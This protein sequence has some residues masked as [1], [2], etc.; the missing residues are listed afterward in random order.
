MDSDCDGASDYDADGDGED[1]D[2]YGGSDCD[3]TDSGVNPSA[4]DTWYDGV[5]SDC[6]GASDYDADGDGYDS[7]AWSGKDCDDT[8]SS[9]NPAASETLDGVDEDCSG[10]VDDLYVSAAEA[11]VV[12]GYDSSMSVGEGGS[13]MVANDV[14]DD[15]DVE[16][17]AT[18]DNIDY[19]Y[20]W[21]VEGSDLAG[22]NADL[23][24][25]DRAFGEGYWD[26]YFPRH[27]AS[28]LGDVD[29]DGVTELLFGTEG[30]SGDTADYG[31]VYGFTG[32]TGLASTLDM[33]YGDGG[34]WGNSEDDDAGK[35]TISDV[36]GDGIGDVILGG[37]AEGKEKGEVAVF[38]GG[39]TL[40]G[41]LDFDDADAA[42][43]GTSNGDEL[44]DHLTSADLD[45]DGYGDF[46]ASAPGDDDGGTDAGA[47]YLF[48]GAASI[49]W[50]GGADTA[51]SVKLTSGT[52]G[53]YLGEDP[54]PV[55]GDVDGDGD[56]D[57]MIPDEDSGQAWLFLSAGSLSSTSV[58][59][60][61]HLF[62][63]T[64]GDFASAVVMDSDLDDDGADDIAIGAD[65]ADLKGT[66]SG[67]VYLFMYDSGWSSSLGI[68]DANGII[69]GDAAGDAF[70]SGLAGGHD[71]DG[72][73]IED[74]VV[75]GTGVDVG[76]SGGGAIYLIPGW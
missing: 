56:L 73:G 53:E 69:W 3:D 32:G 62:S 70:G 44:G 47:V 59:S 22:A 34:F 16:L 19:G 6:D 55:P 43:K 71:V 13:F 31:Y 48:M 30:Y 10:Q 14:T 46:V 57:L 11:G 28:V 15:G 45:D 23:D 9:V 39:F 4:T 72:D 7:D 1:S 66:D 25:V 64:A 40:S 26:G 58:S 5:D 74:I 33:T 24:A 68:S 38:I 63:G 20:V 65:S 50:T 42:V 75:G 21:V 41:D 35:V 49:T 12:Y 76:A 54:L 27:A 51:A 52:A 61:D 37:R 67:G 18:T 60:A 2:A 36:D 8:D 17:V 29:G